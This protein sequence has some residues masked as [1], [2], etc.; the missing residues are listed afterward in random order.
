ALPHIRSGKLRALGLGGKESSPVLPDL[1]TI[2]E[3]GVPGYEA[4][5]WIGIV[6]P[7]GTPAPIVAK[8]Q[9]E[10]AAIQETAELKQQFAAEGVDAMRLGSAEFGAFFAQDMGKW[11]R[12]VR[13]GGIKPE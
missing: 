5:N 4:V 10:I 3:A 9:H 7:A 11:E 13:E 12:V 1:P 2:A 8:L 6:A